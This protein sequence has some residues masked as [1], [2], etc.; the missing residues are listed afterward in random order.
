MRLEE[1]RQVQETESASPNQV[2]RIVAEFERLGFG[3]ADRAGRLAVTA[4]LAGLDRLGSTRDLTLGQAGKLCGML[5]RIASRDELPAAAGAA[6]DQAPE[7]AGPD[8]NGGQGD[9]QPAGPT[10]A[11]AIRDL[12]VQ[13]YAAATRKATP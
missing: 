5:P 3:E 10:L 11:E 9:G 2:G 6:A 1:W 12:I 8:D 7:A 4:A 13:I